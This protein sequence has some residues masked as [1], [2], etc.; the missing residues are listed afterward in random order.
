MATDAKNSPA[1]TVG[2]AQ[3]LGEPLAPSCLAPATAVSADSA[4]G[5]GNGDNQ[6]LQELPKSPSLWALAQAFK[7]KW[8]YLWNQE[9]FCDSPLRTILRLINWRVKCLL[10]SPA[11]ITL[12]DC[13]L[14]MFLPPEWRGIAKLAFTFCERYEPELG[15]LKQILSPGMTFVDAGACY[16]IY[17]LTASK[18]VGEAGRVIAFEPAPRAFRVL[19]KNIRLNSLANV[20]AYPMALAA[21]SGKAL[22]HYH[23]NVGC[24]SLG[25]DDSF[26]QMAEE[27]ETE[28][29]DNVLEKISVHQVDVIKMDVQG[30]EELILR[31]ARKILNAS[32]PVIIFEVYPPCA[33]PLGLSPYGAWEFL[34]DLGYEFFVVGPRGT[35]RREMS[36]PLDR[37]VVAT[38]RQGAH[39]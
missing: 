21:H 25:R 6:H 19:Q 24:D 16:G 14:R 9:G 20:L 10:R 8:H 15:Y 33:A 28:S 22:L 11:T 2:L 4:P 17:T 29:L 39:E 18:L 36:P 31:G 13:D 35:L 5:F 23:P 34:H 32:H 3:E 26:T 27:I 38:Y 12:D 37:N 1:A 7:G 30:A